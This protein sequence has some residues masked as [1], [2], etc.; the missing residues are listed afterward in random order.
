M[1]AKL[2]QKDYNDLRY[3]CIKTCFPD[4]SSSKESACQCWW[5]RFNPW[6]RRSPGEGNGNPIQHSWLGNPMD[7]GA[8]WAYSPC[9][10]KRVGHV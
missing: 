8:R 7:R 2:A 1:D 6:V 4:S 9:G 3:D 10:C 5:C